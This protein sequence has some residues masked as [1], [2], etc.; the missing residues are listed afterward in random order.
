LNWRG[1]RILA[2]ISLHTFQEQFSDITNGECLRAFP[3]CAFKHALAE[4]TPNGQHFIVG[5]LQL[6]LR[7]AIAIVRDSLDSFFLLLPEL[8]AAGTATEAVLSV[9]GKLHHRVAEDVQ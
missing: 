2:R 6:L 4:G 7:L 1:I 8:S 3:G 5:S 9:P